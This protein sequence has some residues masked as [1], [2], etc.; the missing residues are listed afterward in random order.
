MCDNAEKLLAEEKKRSGHFEGAYKGQLDYSIALQKAISA[1]CSGREV[2]PDVAKKCPHLADLLDRHRASDLSQEIVALR[3]R[4]GAM[5]LYVAEAG[6]EEVSI[7]L[8][9]KSM[10]ACGEWRTYKRMSTHIKIE[11]MGVCFPLFSE[12][13]A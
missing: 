13:W 9:S 2:A 3:D 6:A 5:R 10:A 7:P 11:F 1:H 4:A 12:I 8:K